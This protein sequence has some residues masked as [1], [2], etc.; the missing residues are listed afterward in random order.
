MK[1]PIRFEVV[2]EYDAHGD[3]H[4]DP[5]RQWSLEENHCHSNIANALAELVKSD[6]E[7]SVCNI[8]RFSKVT[9][10]PKGTDAYRGFEGEA[11]EAAKAENWATASSP[12]EAIERHAKES[13]ALDAMVEHAGRGGVLLATV[14][15]RKASPPARLTPAELSDIEQEAKDVRLHGSHF[16]DP[17]MALRMAAEVRRLRAALENYGQHDEPCQSHFA[18]HGPTLIGTTEFRPCSCGFDA[19]GEPQGLRKRGR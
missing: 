3:P 17:A 7:Q 14:Q 15:S 13:G 6:D 18:L 11:R 16:L 2:M 9:L 10:L 5:D 4:S 12:A 1:V 19:A 8:C